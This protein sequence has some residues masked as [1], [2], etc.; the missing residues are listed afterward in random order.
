MG[1]GIRMSEMEM[2]EERAVVLVDLLA[3]RTESQM[4]I[5]L[6]FQKQMVKA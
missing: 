1:E 6:A 2:A 4:E 5:D 3:A